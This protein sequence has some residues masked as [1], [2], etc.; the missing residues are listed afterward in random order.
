MSRY[1]SNGQLDDVLVESGD[2]HFIG[3]DTR[4]HPTLLNAGMCQALENMRCDDL[5]ATVRKGIERISADVITAGNA[6]TLPFCLGGSIPIE[7]ITYD[8]EDGSAYITLTV[9]PRPTINEGESML[10]TGSDR[11]EFNQEYIL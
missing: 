3:V 11:P 1:R 8:T 7:S 9:A 2:N 4:V 10:I 5:T 6:L